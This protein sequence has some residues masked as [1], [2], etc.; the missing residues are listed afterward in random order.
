MRAGWIVSLIGHIGAAMMTLLVW[1]TQADLPPSVGSVVPVEI[2]DVALESNVRALAEDVPDEQEA[3]QEEET[4][5][6][7]ETAPSPDAERPRQRTEEFDLAAIARMVDRDSKTGRERQEGERADRNRQ[8]AGLGTEERASIEDR[9][10][11][12]VRAHMRRCWRIPADLPEPDRLIVVVEFNLNRN[13]G[14]TGQPRVTSP[15]NYS[16]DPAMRTAVEYALRA[17]RTCDP[18][19]LPDDPVVGE[20]YE[21][22]REQIYTFRPSS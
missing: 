3:P 18:Y 14:L 20:H 1:E 2:V 19:P 13:G 16:F 7:E 5:E 9:A 21:I 15:R 22:W 8:G 11:A 4:V 12:L 10:R 17:V 6:A